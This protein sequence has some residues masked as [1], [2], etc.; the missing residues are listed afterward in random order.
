[1]IR[2]RQIKV[3]NDNREHL[4][5][6][7]SNLLHVDINDIKDLKV[8]KKSI[9]ARKKPLVFYV[10]EVDI[11]VDNEADILRHN[12]NKDIFVSPKEEYEFHITGKN[13]FKN[14]PIIVG[15][16]PAGLFAAYMLSKYGYKPMI[17]ERGEKIEDR[18]KTVE[19]FW[20]TGSLNPNSNVQFGEGGAGTFSDGKLNTLNKDKYFRGKKVFEIF[21]KCGA[22]KDILT[23]NKPHI[24]T[25]LLRG[26]VSN[27]REEIIKMGG[28]IRYN[29]CLTDI[30][31]KDG[32]IN[33][34]TVN[35][36]EVIPCE[37]VIFAIGHSARET[38]KLLDNKGIYMEP[39]AFAMGVRIE[40]PQKMINE[41]QYGRNND[42][43]EAASYK[44]THT[45]RNGRGVYTFCMCPGGYVVNSSSEENRLCVNGMSN[46]KRD[47]VDSNSALIVTITP[48]DF[49]HHPL[50]GIEFQR[51]LESKAYEVGH[52]KIPVQLFKDFKDNRTSTSLGRVE[53][54]FKGEYTLANLN[55]IFPEYIN[56]ALKE[57][58]KIFDNKI[59]GFSRDDAILAAIEARTSS[60]IRIVR[61][62][63]GEANIKGLYSCGEGAGYAGGITSSAMDGLKIAE[64]IA[65]IYKS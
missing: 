18:V 5:K 35:N 53:P 48:D 43:L 49:G 15:M 41:S 61:D 28:V 65:K 17:I 51:K 37:A 1:M 14:R 26:V 44:L 29:T 39:K 50:D 7:C 34:I 45:C 59:N 42:K 57:G 40:H 36:S 24:G 60:P 23:S 58:I 64:D 27:I 12:M 30:G 32:K 52:G 33:S 10:Y 6:K 2:I 21:V 8:V 47:T 16:G 22:P 63:N 46:Y 4:I 11:T 54:V 62:D 9:D 19:S 38:F 20:N 3:D 25:D 13:T 31:I 56:E 55:E